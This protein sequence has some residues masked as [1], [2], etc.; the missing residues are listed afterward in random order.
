LIR[1]ARTDEADAVG[2]LVER[3]YVPWVLAIG[4]RPAPMDDDYAHHIAAGEVYVL[5]RDGAIAAIA[6]LIE[7]ADHLLLDNVAVEPAWHH[8]GLGR[9]MIGF[10]EGE[11][12]RRGLRELRLFTNALMERNIALYERLGFRE[13]H[14]AQ[15]GE[16]YR[17][18]MTKTVK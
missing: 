11:T 13:T 5:E 9:R 12:R 14:R 18:F 10:A 16:H 4:R 6:V 7:E 3:A 2:A 15:V 17:V 8:A 1:P